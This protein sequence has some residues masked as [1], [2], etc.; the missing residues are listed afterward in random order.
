MY[1]KPTHFL[2]CR[3]AV[4]R[5]GKSY[6]MYCIYLKDTTNNRVKIRVFGDR[7]WPGHY[8]KSY[9]RYVL[10]SRIYPIPKDIL[11]K[12]SFPDTRMI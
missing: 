6:C 8:N 9:I 1:P 12:P 2:K 3:H 11:S 7:F 5:S 10:K 4:G